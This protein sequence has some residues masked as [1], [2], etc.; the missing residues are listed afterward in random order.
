[1]SSNQYFFTSKLMHWNEHANHRD[2]P[3]KGEK[4]PYKI[5]LSEV[6]LQQTRVEQGWAY[7]NRFIKKYPNIKKLAAAK[8][9]DVF[10]LWEG[11]GYYSRC[12][13]LLYT[14]RLITEKN[15]G[16]FPVTYQEV[17]NLKGVGSYTAAAITSFAYNAPHAVVD[18]N[19]SRVLSR[20]F[21]IAT[22]IDST[23]GKK[24]FEAKADALLDKKQ[25]ALYNQALMDLG[26]TICKPRSP[27]CED[28]PFMKNCKAF[29]TE[30]QHLFPIK[31]KQLKIKNRRLHYFIVETK[32]GYWIRKR[33]ENDIWQQLHEF[34]LIETDISVDLKSLKKTKAFQSLF[35]ANQEINEEFE[36]VTQQLTHQAIHASFYKVFLDKWHPGADFFNVSI[37]Q[38]QKLAFPKLLAAFI[39]NYLRP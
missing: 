39:K 12:R 27:L 26:A 38:M 5:W 19:V 32:D 3:W 2:M 31:E 21:G 36:K 20:V 35:P 23:K 24:E 22:P 28:C 33:M 6:I 9:T 4:D 29:V 34:V 37:K 8:D 16:I 17:I 15:N 11:L 25:P 30:S 1:M 18:G 13:N 10:K 14:A 7:Y